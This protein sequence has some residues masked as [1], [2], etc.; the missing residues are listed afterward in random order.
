M[1]LT[2]GKQNADH[3]HDRNCPCVR[4]SGSC[5]A[6]QVAGLKSVSREEEAFFEVVLLF[7]QTVGICCC[8]IAPL[9]SL[10]SY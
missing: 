7:E 4:C 5:D 8:S 2:N 10:Q 1:E 6:H 9:S 3:G